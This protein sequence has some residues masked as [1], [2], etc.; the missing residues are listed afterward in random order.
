MGNEKMFDISFTHLDQEDN[1]YRVPLKNGTLE[2]SDNIGEQIG[3]DE[4][5]QTLWFSAN[6]D[7]DDEDVE[8]FLREYFKSYLAVKGF[9][10][11]ITQ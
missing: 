9:I 7:I 10:R 3:I 2:H 8:E 1:I 5:T 4:D 6:I 11:K